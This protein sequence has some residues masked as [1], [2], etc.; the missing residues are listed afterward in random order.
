MLFRSDVPTVAEQGYPGFSGEGWGGVVAAKG[1]PPE[2]I[3]KVARDLRKVMSDPVIQQRLVEN[4]LMV[5]NMPRDEWIAFARKTLVQ[6][7]DVAR[8]ANIKVD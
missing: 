8:R 1:T 4:G 6:W 2:I 7:G 3:A 5:D